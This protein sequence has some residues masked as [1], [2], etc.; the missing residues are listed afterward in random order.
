MRSPL[1]QIEEDQAFA[2]QKLTA[3]PR[4]LAFSAAMSAEII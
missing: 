4:T 1:G 3:A 2:I